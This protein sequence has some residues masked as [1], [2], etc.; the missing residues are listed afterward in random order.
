[1]QLNE[2]FTKVL[3]FNRISTSDGATLY[4]EFLWSGRKNYFLEKYSAS[5]SND[6]KSLNM[7]IPQ[8]Y[9]DFLLLS[10][11]L[12]FMNDAL[13]LYGIKKNF[14][15][16]VKGLF[17]PYSLILPNIDERIRDSKSSFFYIGAYG[18]DGSRLYID[19]ENNKVFRCS[20][21]SSKPLHCCPR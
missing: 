4:G 10:N 5:N 3:E 6:I 17:Q 16:N 2:I 18:W 11:G 20:R 19:I 15:R 7:A 9:E 8:V 13:A 21:K 12:N 1:M 14:D